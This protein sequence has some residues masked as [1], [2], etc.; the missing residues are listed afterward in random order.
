MSLEPSPFKVGAYPLNKKMEVPSSKSYANR[1]LILAAINKSDITIENI[2]LSSDVR[3]M[4]TCLKKIGLD[5]E[6]A[7]RS[8]TVKGSFPDCEAKHGCSLHTGDGGTTNRFLIPLLSRGKQEYEI[9]PEGHMRE[10]PMEPLATSLRELGVCV[11]YQESNTWFKVQGPFIENKQSEVDCAH[12]TQFITGLALATADLDINLIP[13]NLEVSLP[14]WKLTLNLLEGFKKNSLS[15]INPVD[16]SSLTYPLALAAVTGEVTVCNAHE[17]DVYQADSKFIEIL[18]KMGADIFFDE[19]GLTC[20]K[21]EL[22]AIEFDGSQ[23]P[24][25]IPTLLYVCSFAKGRSR[26]YN[27][28]VLTH[29]ECDRYKEMIRI[30]RE[31]GVNLEI[32]NDKFEIWVDGN[33]ALHKSVELS[34][35]KDHRMVMVS[36]LYMRTLDGGLLHHSEHV[37]KSFANFFKVMEN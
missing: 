24:D 15:Y 26:I 13:K 37:A 17:I 10:R 6:V 5:I 8:V 25:A 19:N 34:P 18:K 14:Y 21:K 9:I 30:M 1:L 11:T 36:Y 27:L 23:C 20:K 4:I 28:E 35:E 16:F 32:D 3:T 29:K 2:P 7:P 31:F 12:S 33:T 22:N